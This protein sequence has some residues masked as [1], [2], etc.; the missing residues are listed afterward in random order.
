MAGTAGDEDHPVDSSA[1]SRNRCAT[2]TGPG[3]RSPPCWGSRHARSGRGCASSATEGWSNS[4]RCTTGAT[5]AASHP[6]QSHDSSKRSPKGYFTTLSK[7]APGF[8]TPL[9]WSTRSRVSRTCSAGSGPAITRSR[10]FS[11]RQMSRNR[12]SGCGVGVQG[13][14]RQPESPRRWGER[15]GRLAVQR[16]LVAPGPVLQHLDLLLRRARHHRGPALDEP[17]PGLPV[18]PAAAL[19]FAHPLPPRPLGVVV[20]RLHPFDSTE[21]PPG[22]LA[23]EQLP[24]GRRRPGPAARPAPTQLVPE[25][26][27]PAVPLGAEEGPGPGPLPPSVPAVEEP[28]GLPPPPLAHRGG[29]AALSAQRLKITRERGPANLGRRIPGEL[30]SR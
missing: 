11:G 1:A 18:G 2:A 6:H 9:E 17:T 5:P 29:L 26:A 8:K 15:R 3:L 27:P 16:D 14:I 10:A 12:G 25:P 28:R 7:C 13:P 20:R 24:A 4:V 23:A 21:R 22:R 30:R 19:A